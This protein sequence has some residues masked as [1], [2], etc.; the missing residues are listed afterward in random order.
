M[1]AL[2]A[3]RATRPLIALI[4]M[5]GA[6]NLPGLGAHLGPRRRAHLGPGAS[7]LGRALGRTIDRALGALCR[8]SRL[9]RGRPRCDRDRHLSRRGWRRR[10][11]R[12]FSGARPLRGGRSSGDRGGC[13]GRC[14]DSLGRP[15]D[16]RG[17]RGRC[18]CLRLGGARF[19]GL[20]L[21]RLGPAGSLSRLGDH[22]RAR[23]GICLARL[24]LGA[25]RLRANLDGPGLDGARF[26]GARL[27]CRGG[28]R[29][30]DDGRGRCRNLGFGGAHDGSCR[31]RCRGRS[32]CG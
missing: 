28:P 4:S 26:D 10:R 20:G 17:L 2:A 21:H 11:A 19:L 6:R 1:R 25:R 23:L 16:A 31:R 15:L 29:W 9:R 24:R 3:V 5:I 32:G 22:R 18:W 27:D 7:A 8:A 30:L 14:L 13:R 12:R